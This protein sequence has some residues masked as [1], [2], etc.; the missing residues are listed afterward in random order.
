MDLCSIF[1]G[2]VTK[3]KLG[4]KKKRQTLWPVTLPPLLPY[5]T[6]ILKARILIKL[7]GLFLHIFSFSCYC[8]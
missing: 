6:W 4:K 7:H 3:D 8:A 5:G 1:P 2:M